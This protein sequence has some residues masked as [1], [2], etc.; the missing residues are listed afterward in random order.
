[1]VRRRVRIERGR[2]SRVGVVLAGVAAAA[3]GM[4]LHMGLLASRHALVDATSVVVLVAT[5]VGVVLH[6][7]HGA[8]AVGHT[9]LG[10][11]N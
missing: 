8:P 7:L 2:G 9:T 4:S 11:W 5:F 10:C 3:L 1:M 6:V